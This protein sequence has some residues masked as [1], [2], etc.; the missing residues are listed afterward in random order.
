MREFG[1]F[2]SELGIRSKA[3]AAVAN[4]DDWRLEC[5]DEDDQA[6]PNARKNT[7]ANKNSATKRNGASSER[8]N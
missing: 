8:M 2:P 1:Q 5:Q 3:P 4:I 7:H 6:L